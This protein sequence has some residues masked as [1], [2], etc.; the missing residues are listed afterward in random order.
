MDLAKSIPAEV[1]GWSSRDVPLASTEFLSGEA[2]K[3][4]NYDGMVNR[5]FT[6]G[7]TTFGVYIAYWGPGKM[8]V[9]LV[10]SH[11]PDRCWTESGWTCIEMRFR[12][13][14]VFD[15]TALKP[16][17][18]R[19]FEPPDGGRP[20]YVLYWHLVGGRLY[21]YGQRFNA[22]PS[23]ILWW[24]GVLQQVLVGSDEQVFIRLT[25]SVPPESLWSDPGLSKV[26]RSLVRLGLVEKAPA[27]GKE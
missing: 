24:K 10:A 14:E 5:E 25:S 4:L 9:Q 8:P 3:V 6:R 12:Q 1:S 19:L 18:W 7:E 22:I 17:E 26:I 23:P 11:T 16:A 27:T 21:D 2:E 20:T 15:A 13:A